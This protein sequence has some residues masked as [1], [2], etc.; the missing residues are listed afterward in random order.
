MIQFHEGKEQSAMICDPYFE[1]G[2]CIDP[3]TSQMALLFGDRG[4]GSPA[5]IKMA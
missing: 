5:S 3:I 1:V 2:H 4:A